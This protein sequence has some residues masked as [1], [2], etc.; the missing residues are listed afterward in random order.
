[1]NMLKSPRLP[2]SIATSPRNE[3]QFIHPSQS[4]NSFNSTNNFS[5]PK[6]YQNPY[7]LT[8][9]SQRQNS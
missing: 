8:N 3:N 2:L 6:N 1:M 5:S 7:D 4:Q 9:T